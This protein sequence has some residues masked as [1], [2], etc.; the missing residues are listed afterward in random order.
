MPPPSTQ[1]HRVRESVRALKLLASETRFHIIDILNSSSEPVCVNDIAEQIQMSHSATSHQLARLED[2]GVVTSKR[3]GQT[4]CYE[5]SHT[6]I[7][8][9]LVSIVTQCK[10]GNCA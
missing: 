5:L 10:E 1:P 4:V 2:R 9:I 8:R 7:T 3:T 6:P